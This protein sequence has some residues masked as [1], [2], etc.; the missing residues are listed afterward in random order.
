MAGWL[1]TAASTLG[2]ES[3]THAEIDALLDATRE[4]AHTTERRY[5]PLTAFLVGVAAASADADR[6]EAVADYIDRLRGVL[7]LDG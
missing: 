2:V 4:V 5:A 1:E 3:L 7:P 6:E